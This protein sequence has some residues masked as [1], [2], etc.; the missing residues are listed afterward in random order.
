LLS[1]LAL[2]CWFHAA[3][4]RWR[5]LAH[6]SHYDALV[7][8]LET[9]DLRD[10]GDIARRF[11]ADEGQTYSEILLY[12]RSPRSSL[13]VKRIRWARNTGFEE[14]VFANPQPRH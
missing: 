8:D 9:F 1:P 10:A 4:G 7:V 5:I 2:Q 12:T 6:D 3:H 14:L 11:V 13:L